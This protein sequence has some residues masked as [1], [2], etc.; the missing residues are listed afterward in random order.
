VAYGNIKAF[1]WRD[2]S[3]NSLSPGRDSNQKHPEHKA[4]VLSN[5]L[6]HSTE[7]D[8]ATYLGDLHNIPVHNIMLGL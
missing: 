7:A 4:G 5:E 1:T 2:L 6:R 8:L 3:H